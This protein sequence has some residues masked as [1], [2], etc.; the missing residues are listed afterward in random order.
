MDENHH[1]LDITSQYGW[2]M[3]ERME[4]RKQISKTS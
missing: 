3:I 2:K 4:M 1:Q